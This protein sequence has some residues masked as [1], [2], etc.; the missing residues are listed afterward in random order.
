MISVILAGGK[1][2]RLWP[3]SRQKRPK[4]LCKLIEDKSMLEHSIERLTKAGSQK[5]L[6]V[7]SSDIEKDVIEISKNYKDSIDIEV[8]SE[9][10]GKN[11]APA[12]GLALSKIFP[13]FSDQL[14]GIFPADHH[15]LDTYAFINAIEQAKLA[16][17]Q[18]HIVT[19]GVTPNRP[20]TA[21]GYIEK[22]KYEVGELIGVFEVNSFRE[23]PDYSTAE[24]YL[25][26]GNH[27]WN[28][29]IYIAKVKNLIDEFEKHLPNIYENLCNGHEHYISSYNLLPNI[30]LDYGIAEK[31]QYLAMVDGDFGW[32]DLGSWSALAELYNSDLSNNICQGSD[33]VTIESENCIIRQKDKSLVLFGVSDLVIIESDEIIL[34]SQREKI[35]DIK[36]L[37]E[38]LRNINREDLL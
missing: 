23:K 22:S 33:I 34:I 38:N 25:S 27:M 5:I 32:C 3:E 13:N 31:T 17:Q 11:T 9:P 21:Y 4:Q 29:G 18:N 14:I 8:L 15:I 20:E 19:I 10:E 7:T 2:L 36:E 24:T 16:A 35:Q 1:G 26:S 12:V 30:S 37:T 6:I 28:A